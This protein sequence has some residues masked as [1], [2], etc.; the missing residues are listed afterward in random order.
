MNIFKEINR[1]QQA[2][3]DNS[4]VTDCLKTFDDYLKQLYDRLATADQ[5]TI[6]NTKEL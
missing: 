1:I 3:P 5:T 4:G 2:Y 6:S